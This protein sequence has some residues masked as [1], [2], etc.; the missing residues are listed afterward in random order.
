MIDFGV[1]KAAGP[2]LTDKTLFTGIGAVVG[3][4]EYMSPEQA[5]LNNRDVDTRSDIYSLGVLLYELLTSTT[6]L[7]RDRVK[8]SS[9]LEVLRLVREEEPPKPSARVIT[10]AGRSAVAANRSLEPGH[11]YGLLR[12]ELDWVVMKCLEKDRNRRYETAG[13]LAAD[14]QHYLSDEPVHAYPPSAWYRFGKFARRNRREVLA[15][16]AFAVVSVAGVGVL[17]VSRALIGRALKSETKA[18]EALAEALARERA[19]MYFQRITVAHRELSID[20]LAA[21]LRAL[22]DCPQDLRGWE[23]HYLMRLFKFEPRVLPDS[24]EVYGVAFSPDGGRIASAGKDGSIKIWNSRTGQVLQQFKAHTGAACG[25]AF[26]PRGGHVASTGTDRL[27]K[28]WDLSATGQP[29]FEGPCDALRPFGVSY[30]VAFRPPDGRYLAAGCDRVVR[31]WD[32][33][34]NRPEVPEHWFHGPEYHSIPVA[35]SRDGRQLA[36]CG[37]WDQGLNLWDAETGRPLG[38]LLA[39][40]H[41]TTALAFSP[42]GQ[43]LASASLGR[44]VSLWDA[45]THELR[46]TLPHDGNVLGVAFSWDGERLAS[47]GEDKTVHIWDAATGREVLGLQG[48]SEM[49]G[50]VAFSPDGGRLASASHDRTIRVWDATPLRADEGDETQTFPQHDEVRCVAVSPDPDG[51][52]VASGGNGTMVRVWDA[53]T[54]REKFNFPGHSA[55]VFSVAW[56]PDSRRIASAGS[57]GG[58]NTVKVWDAR[59]GRD[60]FPLSRSDR[61]RQPARTRSWRSARMAATWSRANWREQYSSGMPGPVKLCPSR[62]H[63]LARSPTC[64]QPTAGKSEAWYSASRAGTWPPQAATER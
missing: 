35:F 21:A 19:E 12:G 38:N 13:A 42:D 46:Q 18:K 24:T 61:A 63:G 4:P 17:S 44:S 41:P 64:S 1:A 30:T 45:T 55:P 25:V 3:T 59:T 50:C 39:H 43:R 36:T 26:H 62:M 23:W 11:L 56:H 57:A 16:G 8:E 22:E 51:L 54:G 37:N 47:V 40:R 31:I 34:K 53:V 60:T 49:G 48:H 6:P 10:V 27:V 5:E 20:N 9:L 29:R 32:W 58:Q 28:V 2:P 52:W 7:D 33:N 14:V 15:A